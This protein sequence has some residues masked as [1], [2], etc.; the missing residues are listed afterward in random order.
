MAIKGGAKL[1]EFR[2]FREIREYN[3]YNLP[4]DLLP[5][6]SLRINKKR[7]PI[8]LLTTAGAGQRLRATGGKGNYK[9][10]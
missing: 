9:V 7:I 6:N 1:R 3:T 2:E 10:V 5:R 4:N 8:L